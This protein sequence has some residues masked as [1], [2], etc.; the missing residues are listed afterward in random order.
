MEDQNN[1]ANKRPQP[2]TSPIVDSFSGDV[3]FSIEGISDHHMPFKYDNFDCVIDLVR[4]EMVNFQ[5]LRVKLIFTIN[6]DHDNLRKLYEEEGWKYRRT[7]S[8]L[9]KYPEFTGRWKYPA[10]VFGLM[11]NKYLQVV[12]ATCKV[13]YQN[14][15]VILDQSA[16]LVTLPDSFPPLADMPEKKA[17]TTTT[18]RRLSFIRI[19]I[20]A[21]NTSLILNLKQMLPLLNLL[22]F[23]HSRMYR[24]KN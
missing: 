23:F 2:R 6:G 7:D 13:K 15:P 1:T 10:P 9:K 8:V 5:I 17:I 4:I 18:R 14:P 12:N 19:C 11:L 16:D 3:G 21:R 24:L 22:L 20:L